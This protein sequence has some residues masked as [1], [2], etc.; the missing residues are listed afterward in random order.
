MSRFRLSH[1]FVSCSAATYLII[2]GAFVQNAAAASVSY[3]S[4]ADFFAA[5]AGNTLTEEQYA[6]GSLG[7]IIPNGGTFNGLTYSFSPEAEGI[8]TD[9][10]NSFSNLSLGGHQSDGSQYFFGGDSVTVNFATPVYA[11]GVFFNV[12]L[13]SGNFDLTTPVGNAS[14]GSSAFDT[15]TFVFAGIISTTAFS[16][17][18]FS[19]EDTSQGSFNIPEIAFVSS[20]PIPAALPLFASGLGALGLLGRR[21]KRKVAAPAA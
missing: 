6:S 2:G 15:K 14:T 5:T 21:R 13:D 11:A 8:I 3:T 19:S 17:I 9:I 1:F 4:S 10:A 12:N 18:T 20:T 7:Q 16:T